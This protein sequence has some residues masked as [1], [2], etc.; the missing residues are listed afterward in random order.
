MLL[1]NCPKKTRTIKTEYSK[2]ERAARAAK[3]KSMKITTLNSIKMKVSAC[4][5]NLENRKW[6]DDNYIYLER[7]TTP[8]NKNHAK[9]RITGVELFARSYDYSYSGAEEVIRFKQIQVGLD[10]PRRTIYYANEMDDSVISREDAYNILVN[11]IQA[12]FEEYIFEETETL[13]EN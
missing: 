13:N 9:V 5:Y 7:I 11:R 3:V 12:I 8:I 1:Y 4:L 10:V 6:G 2:K